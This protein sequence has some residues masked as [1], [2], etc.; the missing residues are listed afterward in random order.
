MVVLRLIVILL[1]HINM[2]TYA[3]IHIQV[4]YSYIRVKLQYSTTLT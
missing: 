3:F 4:L 1:F 2:N